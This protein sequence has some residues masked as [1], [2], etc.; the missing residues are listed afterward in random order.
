MKRFILAVVFLVAI[1]T[2]GTM[3]SHLLAAYAANRPHSG[4]TVSPLS[5]KVKINGSVTIWSNVSKLMTGFNSPQKDPLKDVSAT[6]VQDLSKGIWTITVPKLSIAWNSQRNLVLQDGKV[7]SGIYRSST[8]AV[9]LTV[10]FKNV[11]VVNTIQ[12]NLSTD[13]SY[14]TTDGTTIRGSRIDKKGHFVMVGQQLNIGVL[15]KSSSGP[16]G[17]Y[18][19]TLAS[20][21]H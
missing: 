17:G 13:G 3:P 1:M 2:L 14:K 6:C 12:F 15:R 8:N 21:F 10:P 20:Y 4:K 11:P 19:I 9:S 5:V 16:H 18:R 7:A